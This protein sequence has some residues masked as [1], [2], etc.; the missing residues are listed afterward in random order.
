MGKENTPLSPE[1]RQTINDAIGALCRF[2]GCPACL[3]GC[4]RALLGGKLPW[5]YFDL[6]KMTSLKETIAD[7]DNEDKT[8]IRAFLEGAKRQTI[9]ELDAIPYFFPEDRKETP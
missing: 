7:V 2:L 9:V 3:H 8:Q 6:G 4:P 5:C 1:Q